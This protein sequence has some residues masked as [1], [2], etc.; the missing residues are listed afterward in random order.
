MNSGA[1]N[2]GYSMRD[3]FYQEVRKNELISQGYLASRSG[4]S[5]GSTVD[6][7]LVRKSTLTST[8]TEAPSDAGLRFREEEKDCRD[9]AGIE[10][11]GQLDMG[12]IYDCFSLK[13]GDQA[14]GLTAQQRTN[15]DTLKN[16]MNENGFRGY[17]G[18]WWHFTLENEPYRRNYFDFVVG[19]PSDTEDE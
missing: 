17:R 19:E 5:R 8:G 10:S 4:H 6:L 7:T 12:T 14:T 2:N 3:V 13:S 1:E 11:T 15:R 9:T 16:L 18:E